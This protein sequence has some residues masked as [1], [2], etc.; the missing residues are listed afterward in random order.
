MHLLKPDWA[1]KLL[2]GLLVKTREGRVIERIYTFI[3]IYI[4]TR[5]DLSLYRDRVCRNPPV[6]L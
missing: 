3:Y 4:Y 1:M 2:E 6:K 5:V